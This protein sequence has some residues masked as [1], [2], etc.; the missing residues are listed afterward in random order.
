[1]KTSKVYLDKFKIRYF[2]IFSKHLFKINT[3]SKTSYFTLFLALLLNLP[4]LLVHAQEDKYY[5]SIEDALKNRDMVFKLFISGYEI[6]DLTDSLIELHNLRELHIND[7]RISEIPVSIGTLANLQTLDLSNNA[8]THLPKSIG[9]LGNLKSINLSHNQLTFLP[10]E[11]IKISNLKYLN[12]SYNPLMKLPPDI[13]N[14]ENLEIILPEVNSIELLNNISKF[15]DAGWVFEWDYSEELW[16]ELENINPYSNLNH[17]F[18]SPMKVIGLDLSN[19][20]L[21]ELSNNISLFHFLLFFNLSDNQI[22]RLPESIG[23]LKNLQVLVLSRNQL[24]TLPDSFQHITDLQILSLEENQLT[25]L[26]SPISNLTNLQALSLDYNKL[27][28]IPEW[29]GNLTNLQILTLRGNQ[30]TSLPNAIG[31]LHNLQK[32]VMSDHHLTESEIE[33]INQVLPDNCKIQFSSLSQKEEIEKAKNINTVLKT[34]ITEELFKKGLER[35]G[36][37][38]SRDLPQALRLKFIDMLMDEI[39]LEEVRNIIQPIYDETLSF[40]MVT[41]LSE[42][43]RKPSGQ[44]M[45]NN[46]DQIDFD[47]YTFLDNYLKENLESIVIAG[48]KIKQENKAE[49]N[50][51]ETISYSKKEEDIISLLQIN[52]TESYIKKFINNFLESP[53]LDFSANLRMMNKHYLKEFFWLGL[54]Q[55][56]IYSPIVKLYDQTYS[57][58]EIKSYSIFYESPIGQKLIQ[59]DENLKKETLEVIQY[60]TRHKVERLEKLLNRKKEHSIASTEN[61]F[62]LNFFNEIIN[63]NTTNKEDIKQSF[64]DWHI[65]IDHLLFFRISPDIDIAG[66]QRVLDSAISIY[67][68][69]ESYYGYRAIVAQSTG[70]FD[71]AIEYLSLVSEFLKDYN[72]GSYFHHLVACMKIEAGHIVEG[73]NDLM[74]L[75]QDNPEFWYEYGVGIKNSIIGILAAQSSSKEANYLLASI[76]VARALAFNEPDHY[77]QA[78]IFLEKSINIDNQFIPAISLKVFINSQSQNVESV[79]EDCNKLMTINQKKSGS[80]SARLEAN[81]QLDESQMLVNECFDEFNIPTSEEINNWLNYLTINFEKE[82]DIYQQIK[83]TLIAGNIEKALADFENI[84]NTINLRANTLFPTSPGWHPVLDSITADMEMI[85]ATNSNVE[86]AYELRGFIKLLKEDYQGALE[87]YNKQQSAFKDSPIVYLGRGLSK[88]HLKDYKGAVKDFD[89]S[90]K[91]NS[92]NFKAYYYRGMVKNILGDRKSACSDWNKFRELYNMNDKSFIIPRI[93]CY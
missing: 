34:T 19:K 28:S 75:S 74:Q 48:Y 76:H 62:R 18:Q 77:N 38:L 91:L 30:I 46:Q 80:V 90:I 57:H 40:D 78:L 31:N 70:E 39:D 68:F 92:N 22:Q 59:I 61:L 13:E 81:L 87:N 37:N 49:A 71:S 25:I 83:V 51:Q 8:L 72:E 56:E 42:F 2:V 23:E 7:T 27:T 5:F 4:S 11:L 69:K 12:L 29:I 64:Y 44:K 24:V 60:Y 86:K 85:M 43:S 26:P 52:R 84:L 66:A 36:Q 32:V 53:L 15:E 50:L 54:N 89:K 79:I 45:I 47:Y 35:Q 9:R 73:I 21:N 10:D 93:Y 67:P 41:A 63:N 82:Q 55:N 3:L 20:N 14:L 65:D 6:A 58:E 1:M 33:K 16:E 88:T 17:A